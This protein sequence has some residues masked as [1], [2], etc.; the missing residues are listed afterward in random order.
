MNTTVLADLRWRT[1][2]Q[3]DTTLA[4]EAGGRQQTEHDRAHDGELCPDY[5]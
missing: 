2:L 5:K 3:V 4:D 1:P